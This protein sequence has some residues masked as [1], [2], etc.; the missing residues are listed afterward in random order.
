MAPH[1]AF[2]NKKKENENSKEKKQ[3]PRQYLKYV[4]DSTTRVGRRLVGGVV[5]I[6]QQKRIAWKRK[7]IGCTTFIEIE[8]PLLSHQTFIHSFINTFSLFWPRSRV[9]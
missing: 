1:V 2:K 6:H 3:R 5:D 4:L 8:S 9:W 7:G